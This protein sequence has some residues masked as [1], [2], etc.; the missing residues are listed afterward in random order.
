MQEVLMYFGL[1]VVSLTVLLKASDLFIDSAEK[2]GLSVGIP[3]FIIGVTIV[4]F[5]T[6]LPELATAIVS[7]LKNESELV[8][9]TVIGS[10]VTN[11]ALVLGLVAV[12]VK[13]IDLEYNIWHSDMP[14]L[15]GS[16]FM[17]WLVLSDFQVSTLEAILLLFGIIIF[18]AHSFKTDN[19]KN[20]DEEKI[21]VSWKTY[22]FLLIGGFL[23]YLGADYTVFSIIKLS[24]YAG[25]ESK[26]IGLSAVALGTSLPEIIV[27]LNAARKGKTSIAVGNVLGSNIF[28][29]YIVIGIPALIGPLSIP[30]DINTFYLPLMIVMTILFGVM[31]NNKNFSRSEGFILLLFYAFFL[32][33][34]FKGM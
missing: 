24:A 20:D 10:N 16:A 4:A 13:N 14:H 21:K 11:I 3:P 7:V 8:V 15:W 32:G 12:I 22:L 2:I 5:G 1:F 34:M 25:I 30:D 31:S 18:L 28:N 33:E 27:S 17:F 29:T 19:D 26:I 9:S 6:S 23:V